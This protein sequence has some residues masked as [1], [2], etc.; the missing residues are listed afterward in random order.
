LYL[1]QTAF[2]KVSILLF[3]HRLVQSTYSPR[4]R[5]AI[6]LVIA[7]VTVYS[8]VL[9]I[10]YVTFCVP[11][12]AIWKQY[13]TAWAAAHKL[14][15][16]SQSTG[17]GVA[18][19]AGLM[20]VITDLMTAALPAWLFVRVRLSHRARIGLAVIFALGFLCVHP[21]QLPSRLY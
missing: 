13:D 12:S 15:C 8:L 16:R 4:F 1:A 20:A 21:A 5:Q 18:W 3:Y 6:W 9:F 11:V 17:I 2:A 10:L 19:G 14:H 7:I